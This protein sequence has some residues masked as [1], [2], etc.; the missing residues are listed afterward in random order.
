MMAVATSRASG[1]AA[2]GAAGGYGR[3]GRQVGGCGVG[4][5]VGG[6]R[7]ETAGSAVVEDRIMVVVEC[8]LHSR[9]FFVPFAKS[10]VV[11]PVC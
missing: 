2:G 11:P 5:S 7:G 4:G 3:G 8:R 10:V 1:G 9:C 6:G